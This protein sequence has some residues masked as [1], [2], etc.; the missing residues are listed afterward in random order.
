MTTILV[1]DDQPTNRRFIKAVLACKDYHVLEASDGAEGLELARAQRPHLIIADI[2]MPTMDGFEFVRQVRADASV[3]ETRVLFCTATYLEGE[4]RQLALACGVTDVIVKPADPQHILNTVQ[5]ALAAGKPEPAYRYN[6]TDEFDREHLRLM[7]N[8]LS[9]KIEELEETNLRLTEEVAQRQHVELALRE[10]QEKIQRLSRIQ[11]VLSSINSAIV[12]IRE[13]GP[14]FQEACKIA[15]ECGQ[16]KMAWIGLLET[17]SMKVR[18]VGWAG[19]EEG[20]LDE[21][22]FSSGSEA[23]VDQG[24]TEAAFKSKQPVVCNDL[25]SDPLFLWKTEARE[26]GYGSAVALPLLV[27]GE[28]AGVFELYASEAGF[29]NEKELDLLQDLAADIAFALEYIGKEEKISY[30][31]YYDHL[32]GLPNRSL[33]HDRLNQIVHAPGRDKNQV[34]LVVIDLERF[35]IIN[36][37]FGRRAGDYLLSQVADR[38]R[39]IIYPDNLSHLGAGCFA[40]VLPHINGEAEVARFLEQE[41][42]TAMSRPLSIEAEDLHMSVRAGVALFPGDGDDAETLLRNAEAALKKAKG[43]GDRYLFYTPWMNARV[44]ER[45]TVENRLRRA[46]KEDEF[47]LYYQPKID[48]K[49]ERIN[50]VEALMRWKQPDRAIFPG[51]FIPIL[52]E[53]GMILDVGN[54]VLERAAS[55]YRRWMAKGLNPP[56]ISV[57]VSPLQ[58]RQQDFVVNVANAVGRTGS[59][60]AALDLEITE[61]L[62]MD[63][64]KHSIS[65]LEK[66]KELG[67]DIA[68]DDFGTGYSSLSYIARLPVSAVKIDRSFIIDLDRNP[69]SMSIVSAIISLAHSLNLK[70]IAEGVESDQ[71]S[72]LLRLLRCD[73]I[74][75]YVFSPAVP[76]EILEIMLANRICS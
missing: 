24:I 14:L 46:V 26:R 15:V 72:Q 12:R 69:D 3:A 52:E 37:T 59:G 13:R 67:V 39:T 23:P 61:S 32:T 53:T 49:T 43:S 11:A 66:F 70:V 40:V 1:V 73:E 10:S 19:V 2:L 38:L 35:S 22:S 34:A 30:L 21:I 8:K 29:F 58:L 33:I 7:T 41:I 9:Q 42:S 4:A 48:L 56:P 64:I 68:I 60:L 57:N 5:A 62:I 36:D 18:P 54:W 71:Q 76:P 47:V 28:V 17:V 45:L 31:A 16:F 63:N 74:Q 55:D 27:D 75:G 6:W 65:K 44:A 50:G 51:A 25:E 20:Y